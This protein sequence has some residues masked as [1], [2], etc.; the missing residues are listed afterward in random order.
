MIPRYTL[1]AT[2]D[3]IGSPDNLD[4]VTS[5]D[6]WHLQVFN[7]FEATLHPSSVWLVKLQ[8]SRADDKPFAAFIHSLDKAYLTC[9][10]STLSDAH[11]ALE[12]KAKFVPTKQLLS[13]FF[14]DYDKLIKNFEHQKRRI[15][16]GDAKYR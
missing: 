14:T 6:D 11:E 12:I 16:S 13:Q 15:A 3:K 9:T 5:T 1:Q 7:F 4:G 10:H 2:S 8:T